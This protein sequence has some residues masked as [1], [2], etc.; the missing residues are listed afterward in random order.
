[1]GMFR[2]KYLLSSQA[3]PLVLIIVTS[4]IRVIPVTIAAN[5]IH[6]I[7]TL[8]YVIDE[9]GIYI[10]EHDLISTG[11]GIIVDSSN[12]VIDDNGYSIKVMVLEQAL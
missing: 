12:V 7:D 2:R 1:M 6:V 3:I 9:P 11:D 10:L 8:P 4:A 5:S